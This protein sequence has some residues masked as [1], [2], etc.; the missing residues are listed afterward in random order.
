MVEVRNYEVDTTS[1]PF[2]LAKQWI[3]IH[4]SVPTALIPIELSLMQYFSKNQFNIIIFAPPSPRDVL[5]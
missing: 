5:S 3:R 1:A 4:N 2:S